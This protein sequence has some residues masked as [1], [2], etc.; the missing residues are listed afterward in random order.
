M[1]IH[2]CST[3]VDL[4]PSA[5]FRILNDEAFLSAHLPH[6]GSPDAL[7]LRVEEPETTLSWG[8]SAHHPGSLDVLPAGNGHSELTLRLAGDDDLSGLTTVTA[9]AI[10]AVAEETYA[11]V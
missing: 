3:T 4:P 1:N 5:L 9:A 2:E 8:S 10:K 6:A 11:E 7:W